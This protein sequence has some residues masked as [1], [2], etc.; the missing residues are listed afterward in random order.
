LNYFEITCEYFILLFCFQE[1][2]AVIPVLQKWGV[3]ARNAGRV[4]RDLDSNGDGK[5]VF[6]RFAQ[7]ALQEGD[8]LFL[9]QRLF[10]Q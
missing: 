9:I 1:F 3:N 4:Y 2:K 8:I 5:V 6:S 7:W 10:F